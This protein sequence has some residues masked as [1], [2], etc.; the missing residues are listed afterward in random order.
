MKHGFMQF[1]LDPTS[2]HITK[3]YTHRGL[4][5]S[6]RLTFSI[7][8]AAEVFHEEM[9]QTLADIRNIYDDILIHSA[10]E[11]EH[12]ITLCQMLPRLEDCGLTLNKDKC[13]FNKSK[14]NFFGVIFS[15]KGISPASG[16]YRSWITKSQT[17]THNR[18]STFISRH[19]QL[20]FTLHTELLNPVS[21]AMTVDQ[22][23]PR[24]RAAH[25]LR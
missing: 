1:E 17:S 3:L 19:G 8:S 21:S 6:R 7:N 22:P 4:R 13:V 20:Q 14:I 2:R 9:H 25:R 10:T 5:R 15:Q 24:N 12:D 11:E 18:R 23:H 16:K